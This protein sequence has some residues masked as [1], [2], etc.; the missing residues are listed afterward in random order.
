[1]SGDV[2]E[3]LT[4]EEAIRKLEEIVRRMENE[5]IPLEE[6]LLCFQEGIRL[7]RY[8]REK[9]AEIE[10]RVEYLLKE[11]QDARG[12]ALPGEPGGDGVENGR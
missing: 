12:Q 2:A 1:M 8:C 7:S 6:A 5:E 9:L 3:V 10:Y 4:Y 11:E